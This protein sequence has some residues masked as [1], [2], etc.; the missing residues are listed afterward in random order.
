MTEKMTDSRFGVVLLDSDRLF[1]E[2]LARSIKNANFD[3]L[4]IVSHADDVD[5][6]ML[7]QSDERMLICD[8]EEDGETVLAFLRKARQAHPALKL[9]VL[10]RSY[11]LDTLNACLEIGVN[12]YLNKNISFDSFLHYLSFAAL[13]EKVLP[14]ELASS[15]ISA[16][17]TATSGP[18]V[19][20]KDIEASFS[21]RERAILAYLIHGE[22]NKEIA[23]HLGIADGT[24]K[25]SVKTILRKINAHNRTQAAIWA[26]R[27]GSAESFLESAN[28]IVKD[29]ADWGWVE[30]RDVDDD[31]VQDA[32][33]GKNLS[34]MQF[35][36]V[37][38]PRL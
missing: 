1:G 35:K 7:T 26:L 34:G 3:V 2:M 25:V 20:F 37:A 5:L 12:A 33:G 32:F 8:V 9:V 6:D 15:F 21:D 11:A 19:S 14:I 24:V 4:D 23:R 30:D 18:V 36:D 31:P 16:G 17:L 29:R 10:T 13:D 27:H 28:C 38:S 22:S